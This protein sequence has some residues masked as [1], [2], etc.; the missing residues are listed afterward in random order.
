MNIINK[1]IALIKSLKTY[2]LVRILLNPK[3][4]FW[5]TYQKIIHFNMPIKTI[6]SFEH[7]H[8]LEIVPFPKTIIDVGFNKGQ[9]SSLILFKKKESIVYAFDPNKGETIS[10]GARFKKK[11]SKRFEFYN[12][13]L[14]DIEETKLLN[15]AISSDNNTFL[16]PTKINSNLYS[17]VKLSGENIKAIIKPLS[18]FNIEMAGLNNLL[19]ID[20]QGYELNVLKGIS[21]EYYQQ[22]KWIYI[23]L[24]DFELYSGQ[25]S[26]DEINSYLK[27]IGYKLKKTYNKNLDKDKNKIIYCDA[28]YENIKKCKF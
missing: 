14:G 7:K 26:Y 24:S 17:K 6:P 2:T 8:I 15:I 25:S 9:F 21:K 22:I 5:I 28:L 20:V 1:F 16:K 18:A 10:I 11:F 12:F 3:R 4:I 27:N 13:A 23:E 19:K